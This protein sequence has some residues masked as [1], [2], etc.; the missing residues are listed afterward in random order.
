M[1]S[2]QYLPRRKLPR[3]PD[4]RFEELRERFHERLC[5]D[6]RHLELLNIEL[7][8]R[9]VDA[10]PSY[11]R[12]RLLAHRIC[13]AAALYGNT[14]IREAAGSLEWTAFSAMTLMEK[15]DVLRASAVLL[16][17]LTTLMERGNTVDADAEDAV[18]TAQP[19]PD[20]H[21]Y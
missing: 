5:D 19:T 9:T 17:L 20:S 4:G 8:G 10:R 2:K 6:A 11:E 13:G 15:S 14:A 16:A 21:K 1:G 12:I 7:Q 3:G 18:T